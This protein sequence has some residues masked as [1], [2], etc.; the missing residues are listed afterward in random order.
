MNFFRMLIAA[1]LAAAVWPAQAYTGSLSDVWYDPAESGWGVNV[2]Q[3]GDTALVTLMV[4]APDG[5]PT[6]YV[7]SDA[8]VYAWSADGLPYFRGTLYRTRGMWFGGPFD[9][10]ALQVSPV[11]EVHLSPLAADALRVE[12][13]VGGVSVVKSVRRA[14]WSQPAFD[15]PYLAGFSLRVVKA[16]RTVSLQT[17]TGVTTLRIE[18]GIATMTVADA[19]GQCDYRGAYVQAG[20]LGRFAGS[21]FCGDARSGTFQ[22]DELEATTHGFSGRLRAQWAGA[23]LYG[24][25]GGPRR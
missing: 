1:W 25:F 19:A 17:T 15:T 5:E 12:Y 8:S 20:R 23:S 14:T 24:A 3:Q 2:A 21:F 7:S 11:G 6:W 13:S 4:Y 10:R 22:V 18:D 16:D 9:P